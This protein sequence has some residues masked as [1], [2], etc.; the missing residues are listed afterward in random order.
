MI[1]LRL[2]IPDLTG[3]VSTIESSSNTI[4]QSDFRVGMRSK[5]SVTPEAELLEESA[6]LLKFAPMSKCRPSEVLTVLFPD[7]SPSPSTFRF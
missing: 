2:S 3:I 7:R 4:V 5:D 6:S 1:L